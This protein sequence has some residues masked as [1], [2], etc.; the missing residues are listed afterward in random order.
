[1]LK[2]IENSSSEV[3]GKKE[4]KSPT[5]SYDKTLSH[6]DSNKHLNF[7]RHEEK[8]LQR[9]FKTT[10]LKL[11]LW[12]FANLLKYRVSYD[13]NS[14]ETVYGHRFLSHYEL[15]IKETVSPITRFPF[16]VKE[17]E[18]GKSIILCLKEN[19]VTTKEQIKNIWRSFEKA[20][21]L[22]GNCFSI[23]EI[24][25]EKNNDKKNI[26]RTKINETINSSSKKNIKNFIQKRTPSSEE[27]EHYKDTK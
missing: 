23:L 1:M 5:L 7:L 27:S 15:P 9:Q 3:L 2:Y 22:P 26:Y 6:C 21:S 12:A 10:Q 17:S 8:L 14:L 18:S 4:E 19:K 11:S 25:L 20:T 24:S 13:Y 16:Y